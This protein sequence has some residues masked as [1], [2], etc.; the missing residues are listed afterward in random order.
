MQ[1]TS[2]TMLIF[3]WNPKASLILNSINL[4]GEKLQCLVLLMDV[5]IKF[6]I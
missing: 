3:K 1:Y 5:D 6:A 4:H 2:I